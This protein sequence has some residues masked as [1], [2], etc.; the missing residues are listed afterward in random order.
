MIWSPI[1]K[2]PLLLNNF[3][4]PEILKIIDIEV[5]NPDFVHKFIV[6]CDGS[7]C[8]CALIDFDSIIFPGKLESNS[9]PQ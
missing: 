7:G 8:P 9:N 6:N 3:H 1:P 4:D 5:W 2:A